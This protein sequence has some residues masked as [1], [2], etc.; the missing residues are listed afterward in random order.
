[1]EGINRLQMEK[2]EIEGWIML[3]VACLG[4]G[5]NI[6]IACIL[7]YSGRESG[8]QFDEEKERVRL[9]TDEVDESTPM[10]AHITKEQ[11]IEKIEKA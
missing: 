4:L 2:L 11:Q 1:M 6:L 5:L 3:L 8:S 9:S 7:F 10:G